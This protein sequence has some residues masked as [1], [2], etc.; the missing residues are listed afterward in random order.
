MK[1]RIAQEE[2]KKKEPREH[3]KSQKSSVVSATSEDELAEGT[4]S[5]EQP[6]EGNVVEE[7]KEEEYSD[8]DDYLF[9]VY[10]KD[11][12]IQQAMEAQDVDLFDELLDMRQEAYEE[13][14]Q[15]L[16]SNKFNIADFTPRE[17][18]QEKGKPQRKSHQ[19]LKKHSEFNEFDD[20]ADSEADNIE[21]IVDKKKKGKLSKEE[22]ELKLHEVQMN[23]LNADI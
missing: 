14:Q 12:E 13:A 5:N 18:T 10:F 8:D 22:Q 1:E 16:K 21:K 7:Q 23:A 19:K 9:R 20:G 3:R 17:K 2:S 15:Y 6:T 4:A 11:E